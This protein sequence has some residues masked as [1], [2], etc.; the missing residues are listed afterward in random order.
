MKC[1]LC[2]VE[3]RI[4][5]TRNILENDNTPDAETKLFVEQDLTCL[6]KNCSNFERVVQTV[7]NEIPIG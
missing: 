7:R 3:M 2:N 6:N 1:P 4:T 5:K